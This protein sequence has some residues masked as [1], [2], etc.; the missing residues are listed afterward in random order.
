M[1]L[2]HGTSSEQPALL[3][4]QLQVEISTLAVILNSSFVRNVALQLRD[5]GINVTA[6][7][8]KRPLSCCVC[9]SEKKC[10]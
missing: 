4:E 5:A 6:L 8:A 9:S 3:T 7:D 2:E 10:V 1:P